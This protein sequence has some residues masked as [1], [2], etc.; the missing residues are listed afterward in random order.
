M[1][2]RG[3]F[4]Y[5]EYA[6]TDGCWPP[7]LAPILIPILITTMIGSQ[8]TECK[9]LHAVDISISSHS[10]EVRSYSSKQKARIAELADRI[11]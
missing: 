7:S 9:G 5:A 1:R 3:V 4:E 8:E 2:T 11:A 6:L 10:E